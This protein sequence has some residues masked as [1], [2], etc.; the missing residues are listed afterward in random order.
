MK[1]RGFFSVEISNVDFVLIN[2]IDIEM[3][4]L[5]CY[6]CGW[7]SWICIIT[8]ILKFG[9]FIFIEII[10]LFRFLWAIGEK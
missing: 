4:A 6:G 9:K 5:S 8:H 3:V 7:W 10:Y 1:G 2:G